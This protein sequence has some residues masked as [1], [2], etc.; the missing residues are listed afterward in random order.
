MILIG[1]GTGIAPLIGFAWANLRRRP[2]H[3]YWGGRDPSSDHLYEDNLAQCVDDGRLTRV[4]TAFS[5]V[6]DGAYVQERIAEDAEAL[7]TLFVQGARVMVCGG[8]EMAEGV[9]ASI[10]NILQPLGTDVGS[11]RAAGRYLE[12]VY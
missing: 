10:D 1:A 9:M 7:R 2:M 4:V 3:L 5:R 12:D 6:A 11:L 8:K